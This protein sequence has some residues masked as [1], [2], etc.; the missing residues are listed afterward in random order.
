MLVEAKLLL[1][2]SKKEYVQTLKEKAE[3]EKRKQIEN[4]KKLDAEKRKEKSLV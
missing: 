4:Q 3:A 2:Q 1:E